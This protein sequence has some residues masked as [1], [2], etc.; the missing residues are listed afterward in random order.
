MNAPSA[1]GPS[2]SD[3]STGLVAA[4]A[5]HPVACNLL[6]AI[7]ILAGVWA[8]TRLNTQFFP[9]FDIEFITV[10]VKWTGA[11]AEDVAAAVTEPIERELVGLDTVREMTSTSSRGS[12]SIT[13][14]YEEGTDM[15]V[16]LE[17]VKERVASIRNLPGAADEPTIRRI[18]NYEEVARLLVT[19]PDGQSLRPIVR[20]IERELLDRGIA[21]V[22][23]LGLP[24]EEIAIQVPSATLRELD[25]SLADIARRVAALSVDLPAGSVG[26]DETAKQLRALEQQ[27]DEAGFERLALRAGDDGRFLALGDVATVERRARD[28]EIRTR[29]EGRP[30]VSLLVSR[31]EASDSL[32]S[33]RIFHEWIDGRRGGWPPG[34]EVF[35]YDESWELIRDRT[36]LLLKNGASGLILVVAVLFLFLNTRVAFWVAVGIPVSFMATLGVLYGLG[37]SINMISLFAL[38]MAFGIIVDDA[39]VVGEDALTR[40]QAGDAPLVAARAAAYRMLAPVLASSLTTVAAFMPLMLVSGIIGKILFDIPLVVIC[41]IIASL[42]E[43]FLILP[44]HLYHTFRKSSASGAGAFRRWFDDGFGRFRD[45]TF[46]R[47]V[48]A[49]VRRPWT[50]LSVALAAMLLVVGLLRGDRISFNFFPTPEGQILIA[51]VSFAAGTPPQRVER[52]VDHLEQTLKET[53]AHFGETLVDLAVARLSQQERAGQQQGSRGDQF[54]SLRVQLVEPDGRETRNTEFIAEWRG[55][56]VLAPGL[57]SLSLTEVR[58]GPPGRDVEVSLTGND[59]GALKAAALELASVL[60]TVPG[61]SGIEDDMPF[62][63]EQFIVRLTPQ[64]SA[65]GLTVSDVGQQL[66]AAYDGRVAQIFQHEGEEIEVRVMLPDDERNDI[67]SLGYLSVALPGGGVMPLLTAV[68]IDTRRGFDTL[69]HVNARLGVRVSA[70]VDPAVTNANAVVADLSTGP[71]VAIAERHGVDWSFKGRQE[72]QAETLSDMAWGAGLA[73][74][75]IYLVLAFVFA[76]YGWPL[77]V[78]SVIPFGLVGAVFG[79]WVM[80]IDLTVLSMFGFFGLAGIVVNNSIILVSFYKGMKQRGHPWRE[81]VVDAAC[82]RLRAVLLTSLTTI[83]GLTPLLFETSVQ[84]QFLIPMAV[85]I[86]FGLAFATFLVLLL[87]PALLTVHESVAT[88]FERPAPQAAPATG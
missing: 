31:A 6:M 4:F 84:A 47:L 1:P 44:G 85:S 79:H 55:R 83:G 56:I 7:M 37:G 29:F 76:S 43:S 42:I 61:V 38:I 41:V 80:G 20:E 72:D 63:Q 82:L 46:R 87:V 70:D 22:E 71:L 65:L 73:L 19:G 32:E 8:L 17:Q 25:M 34:V 59:A 3:R 18:I 53:E 52:F 13:L 58:A 27:R 11:S 49:A 66:R 68:D 50:T 39:I 45:H 23:I 57:E 26:R 12:S 69:R 9:T 36:M 2:P 40:R 86:A 30:S 24:A 54:A 62:G 14:E 21:K 64:A 60:V 81:A 48:T 10:T 35:A 28:G 78:M 88:R 51:S 15:A 16:A 5:G 77:V 33:A 75:L 67:A 74:A